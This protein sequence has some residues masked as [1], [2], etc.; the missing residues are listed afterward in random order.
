M[1]FKKLLCAGEPLLRCVNRRRTSVALLRS[2]EVTTALGLLQQFFLWLKVDL[3]DLE[4]LGI[5][6]P[7]FPIFLLAFLSF[8][9]S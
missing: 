9:Q 2:F 7:S 4:T 6:P 1:R 5:T 8:T 3:P